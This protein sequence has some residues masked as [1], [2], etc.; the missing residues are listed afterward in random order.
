[1]LHKHKCQKRYKVLLNCISN[2]PKKCEKKV[3]LFKKCMKEEEER[4][5]KALSPKRTF[6]TLSGND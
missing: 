5:A 1:M 2:N 3:S 6:G 4:G